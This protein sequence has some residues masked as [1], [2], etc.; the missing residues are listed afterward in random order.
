MPEPDRKGL[1]AYQGQGSRSAP[2]HI[3]TKLQEKVRLRA[4]LAAVQAEIDG[5]LSALSPVELQDLQGLMATEDS[6]VVRIDPRSTSTLRLFA[7]VEIWSLAR[8]HQICRYVIVHC[9]RDGRAVHMNDV[10]HLDGACLTARLPALPIEESATLPIP[11]Q[12]RLG[13]R[14]IRYYRSRH[15]AG[16]IHVSFGPLARSSASPLALPPCSQSWYGILC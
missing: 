11:R 2:R 4:S 3:F 9:P 12:R 8:M 13:S 16:P 1:T 6:C 10:V 15:G 7:S 5:A 14:R